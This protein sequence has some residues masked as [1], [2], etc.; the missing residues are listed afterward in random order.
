MPTALLKQHALRE[1]IQRLVD[2]GK[3]KRE[4][5][6]SMAITSGWSI[7]KD[8]SDFLT[9]MTPADSFRF[10]VVFNKKIDGQTS[11]QPRHQAPSPYSSPYCR[12]AGKAQNIYFYIVTA[13]SKDEN[14]VFLGYTQNTQQRLSTLIKD[15]TSKKAGSDT[16]AAKIFADNSGSIGPVLVS[17]LD[18]TTDHRFIPILRAFWFSVISSTQNTLVGASQIPAP[19]KTHL[20]LDPI[21]LDSAHALLKSAIACALPFDTASIADPSDLYIRTR[22]HASLSQTHNNREK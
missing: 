16:L 6:V 20:G 10:R 2:Q 11:A 12:G 14:L 15:S 8:E 9:L 22:S 3:L 17:I 13:R 19:F 4:A 21:P 1:D 7:L 5:V 18:C